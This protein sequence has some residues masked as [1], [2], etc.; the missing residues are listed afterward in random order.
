MI[1]PFGLQ[2]CLY[3]CSY[4]AV[5]ST[6]TTVDAS[7]LIDYV[8]RTLRNSLYRAVSCANAA[9]DAVISD[10]KCHSCSSF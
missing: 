6:S 5:S 9:T 4:R 7:A 2:L 10:L 3:R 1:I 8:R